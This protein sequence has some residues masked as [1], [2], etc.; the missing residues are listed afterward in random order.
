VTGKGGTGAN[1]LSADMFSR[2]KRCD[3]KA[4][5]Q[6]VLAYALRG[7]R[8]AAHGHWLRCCGLQDSGEALA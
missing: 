4:C 5:A 8:I 3:A 2:C 6:L 7:P 1:S